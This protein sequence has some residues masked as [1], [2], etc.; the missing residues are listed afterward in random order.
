[1]A[2]LGPRDRAGRL[3]LGQRDGGTCGHPPPP[4]TDGAGPFWDTQTKNNL[5]GLQI[6]AEARLLERD[7]FSIGGV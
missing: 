7:R 2:P 1:M 6:G 4:G 5:Y 3:P